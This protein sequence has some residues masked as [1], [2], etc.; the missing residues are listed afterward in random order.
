MFIQTEIP[1]TMISYVQS[2][3][4][5]PQSMYYCR[6]LNCFLMP[7]EDGGTQVCATSIEHAIQDAFASFNMTGSQK[8]HIRYVVD[9]VREGAFVSRELMLPCIN[10]PDITCSTMTWLLIHGLKERIEQVEVHDNIIA[11]MGVDILGSIH[12]WSDG[13][14][15]VTTTDSLNDFI[16]DDVEVIYLSDTDDEFLREE[17]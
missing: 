10:H 9:R 15:T 8:R 11:D 16:V 5:E 2:D 13:T 17:V 4:L 6:E 3:V 12:T 7:H 14:D 1:A